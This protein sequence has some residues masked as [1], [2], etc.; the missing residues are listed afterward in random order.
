[1]LNLHTYLKRGVIRK[2]YSDPAVA[3]DLRARRR[4]ERA[5]ALAE[6]ASSYAKHNQLRRSAEVL[7]RASRMHG[8][9]YRVGGA[10]RDLESA[11][12]RNLYGGKLRGDLTESQMIANYL[13]SRN[14][15]LS[16]RKALRFKNPLG[17]ARAI[18]DGVIPSLAHLSPTDRLVAKLN[19]S[20][21]NAKQIARKTGIGKRNIDRALFALSQ[22]KHLLGDLGVKK[23]LM[24]RSAMTTNNSPLSRFRR[25]RQLGDHG[26]RGNPLI[27]AR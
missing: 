17:E 13:N 15:P 23:A 26:F 9:S 16:L 8:D 24:R 5:D 1:M 6:R 19:A 22:N 10:L 12:V 2:S 14:A 21:L 4:R 20:G 11:I 7:A 3:E 25:R 18:R 27:R